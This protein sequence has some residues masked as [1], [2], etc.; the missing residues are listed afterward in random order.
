MMSG[1]AGYS[2]PSERP[3]LPANLVAPC[4]DI[5]VFDS[6]SW[7]ELAEAYIELVFM[8]GECRARHRVVAGAL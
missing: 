8:Y 3:P 1:C 6:D 2:Q 7:D 5:P 4:P